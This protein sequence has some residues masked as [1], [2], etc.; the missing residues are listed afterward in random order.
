MDVK[1]IIQ[2]EIACGGSINV[3]ETT[4]FRILSAVTSFKLEHRR[5]TL[6]GPEGIL[7]FQP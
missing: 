3:Q 2:T 4:Y 6:S 5:L 7:V 1:E